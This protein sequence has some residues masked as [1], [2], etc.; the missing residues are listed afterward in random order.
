LN[1]IVAGHARFRRLCLISFGIGRPMNDGIPD[2]TKRVTAVLVTV[3][4]IY[5]SAYFVLV[6]RHWISPSGWTVQPE[7][8]RQLQLVAH[9]GFRF[10]G[11]RVLLH[12]ARII[13]SPMFSLDREV[14]RHDYWNEQ[15]TV[16]YV[17]G[18]WYQDR[19][20]LDLRAKPSGTDK[21][22]LDLRAEPSSADNWLQPFQFDTLC[23]TMNQTLKSESAAHEPVSDLG[24]S[25]N[26]PRS[27][28]RKQQYAA[29]SNSLLNSPLDL[30]ATCLAR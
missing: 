18:G 26:K 3:F 27:F 28:G 6:E 9:Q 4:S 17:P 30:G 21:I 24:R 8:W 23:W 20:Q 12:R 15:K 29:I 1:I 22:Q 13:F 14:L 10:R 25:A 16:H 2:L 5:A 7:G 19:I 11:D